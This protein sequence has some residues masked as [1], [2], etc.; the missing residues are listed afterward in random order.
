[1]PL[2]QSPTSA[3]VRPRQDYQHTKKAEKVQT[4]QFYGSK[5]ATRFASGG[6]DAKEKRKEEMNNNTNETSS[7]QGHNRNGEVVNSSGIPRRSFM[8]TPDAEVQTKQRDV[9]R[10][11]S[12]EAK[13]PKPRRKLP[14]AP[15]GSSVKTRHPGNEV[16]SRRSTPDN[17]R[18]ST[19]EKQVDKNRGT[20][21]KIGQYEKN[22]SSSD[23]VNKPSEIA[24]HSSDGSRKTPEIN[25]KGGDSLRQT[26]EHKSQEAVARKH[27]DSSD[28]KSRIK[29]PAEGS[30]TLSRKPEDIPSKSKS[31]LGGVKYNSLPR[32]HTSKNHSKF[33]LDIEGEEYMPKQNGDGK[34][35]NLELNGKPQVE[36]GLDKLSLL[37]KNSKGFVNGFKS[38]HQEAISFE[39]GSEELK[40]THVALYKFLPRHKDEVLLEEGDPVSVSKVSEDLWYEGTNLASGKSGI[41]PNRY[42]ADILAGSSSCKFIQR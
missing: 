11:E 7:A 25:R 19:P 38:N 42:V 41:F 13:S 17:S 35:Q 1:M 26:P 28:K 23:S 8:K 22:S 12:L 40:Q 32:S 37:A 39:M 16:V 27:S 5:R 36:Y 33:Y 4:E 9:L 15:T 29:K 34:A 3:F 6:C 2:E 10:R 21:D 24:R 31:L 20:P 18:R 30:L 14:S